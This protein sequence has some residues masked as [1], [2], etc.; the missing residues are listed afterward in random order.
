MQLFNRKYM[1]WGLVVSFLLCPYFLMGQ[2][3]LKSVLERDSILIGDQVWWSMT[4]PKDVWKE[5]EIET[6]VFPEPP[7]EIMQGVE[8]LSSLQLDSLCTESVWKAYRSS[9]LL[10]LLTAEPIG[11][12]ICPCT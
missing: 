10:R 8:G 7:F 11:C 9:C 2:I 5:R 4:L 3:D 12:L 1:V 6:V